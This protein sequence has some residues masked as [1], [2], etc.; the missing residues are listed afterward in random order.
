MFQW[1]ATVFARDIDDL[2]AGCDVFDDDTNQCVFSNSA[3]T[4]KVRGGALDF[5]GSFSQNVSATF[6]YAHNRARTNG[7]AQIARIPEDVTKA[8]LDF[9]P[10]SS[11]FGATIALSYVGNVSA[12]VGGYPTDDDV[13]PVAT[14]TT[15]SSICPVAT[16]WARTAS[17][18]S[19]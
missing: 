17:N 10:A 3:S 13:T 11:P 5:M 12:E 18:G 16:S 9:H 7:G 1:Q 4:V 8:S 19:R 2:I 14:E 6:S 15:R